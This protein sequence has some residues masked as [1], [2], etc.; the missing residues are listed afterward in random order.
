MW[1]YDDDIEQLRAWLG[2]PVWTKKEAVFILAGILPDDK[3][4]N[5][6]WIPNIHYCERFVARQYKGEY[7]HTIVEN[8]ILINDALCIVENLP[9]RNKK[10]YEQESPIFWLQIF[11]NEGI[12][13][14]P[15]INKVLS[16][17]GINLQPQDDSSIVKYYR[18]WAS[19]ERWSFHNTV[20]L[21]CRK[22]TD[23]TDCGLGGFT[24]DPFGYS[25]CD[26]S[27]SA[28]DDKYSIEDVMAKLRDTIASKGIEFIEVDRF[29][30]IE[31]RIKPSD[32]VKWAESKGYNYPKLL[33]E[34]L[35]FEVSKNQTAGNAKAEEQFKQWFAALV[36]EKPELSCPPI[37]GPDLIS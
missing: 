19:K 17:S 28:F 8:E 32:A 22:N 25:G 29:S 15:I 14:D 27:R 7:D 34:A 30:H 3:Y 4:A 1:H 33:M 23:D 36:K 31:R 21:L 10:N 2:K 35:G 24:Y 26:L 11:C 20:A 16:E 12:L 18:K 13:N 5:Y 9:M 6:I 37:I